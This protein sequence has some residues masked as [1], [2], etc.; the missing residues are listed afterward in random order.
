ME[1]ATEHGSVAVFV[2]GLLGIVRKS[3]YNI[4][5]GTTDLR[6]SF[7]QF[8]GRDEKDGC[9]SSRGSGMEACMQLS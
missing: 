6:L 3:I 4:C 5:M 7:S 8:V 1:T 2:E 9:L